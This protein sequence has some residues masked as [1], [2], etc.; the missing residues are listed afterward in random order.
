MAMESLKSY[1]AILKELGFKVKGDECPVLIPT[2]EAIENATNFLHM[3]GIKKGM[4]KII[5]LCP[6]STMKIK[7]WSPE[8]AA[9]LCKMFSKDDSTRILLFST[10]EEYVNKILK[11]VKHPPVVVGRL[12]FN[13][14][15]ALCAQCDL[16]ISVD[17]GP[18]H[19]AAAVGVP[20]IGIF[21]PT[22]GKMFGPYGKNCIVI[23]KTPDC[24][25]YRPASFFSQDTEEFQACYVKD[26]CQFMEKTCV[27]LV[28]PEE[29]IEAVKD[30][31]AKTPV[32][33]DIQ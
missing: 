32:K 24:S 30:L 2:D 5:G 3:H 21:G 7:E 4:H 25:F 17:T 1:L 29:V 31:S 12:S 13:D 11:S 15:I 6:T 26:R 22:S 16:F 14:L 23:Q 18:M 28:L 8:K 9:E 10:D 27:D 19:V 33:L 20:T